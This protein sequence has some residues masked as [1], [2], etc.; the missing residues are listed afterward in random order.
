VSA[1]ASRPVGSDQAPADVARLGSIDAFEERGR[2]PGRDVRTATPKTDAEWIF[3][4]T[5]DTNFSLNAGRPM[6]PVL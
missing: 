6:P 2:R 1:A 5:L 3:G 4:D